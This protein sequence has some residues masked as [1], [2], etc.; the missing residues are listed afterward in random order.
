VAAGVQERV[1]H[2]VV[3]GHDE[4]ALAAD[5]D[6]EVVAALAHL[7]D[8]PDAD[9]AAHEDVLELPVEHA[10]IGER[11]LRQRRRAL[12]RLARALELAD[13]Q[14]QRLVATDM[15]PLLVSSGRPRQP[16][17]S[18]VMC[19][20]AQLLDHPSRVRTGHP[21]AHCRSRHDAPHRHPHPVRP[22]AP[23]HGA[24][25]GVRVDLR[26]DQP[27][28]PGGAG[29]THRAEEPRH[30]RGRAAAGGGRRAPRRGG[31]RESL[32]DLAD[33]DEF[34]AEQAHS[35]A[36]FATPELLRTYRLPN[37][38][39]NAVEVADRFYVKPLLRAVTFPQAGFVLALRPDPSGSWR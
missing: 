19:Q 9:P 23:A 2:A 36:V 3:V 13:R 21:R 24:R 28:H 15:R 27:A 11:R 20:V 6:H 26:G 32:D 39:E 37:R 17:I 35:L 4:D 10:R 29:L 25:A 34:W 30:R 5:L 33:D 12:E 18:L 14:G 1:R 38:L 31:G 16:T 8:V 22:R 7:V